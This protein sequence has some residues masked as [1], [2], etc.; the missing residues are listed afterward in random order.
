MRTISDNTPISMI[1]VSVYRPDLTLIGKAYTDDEGYYSVDIPRGESVTVRFDTHHTLNNAE[2]W[3]P[4]LVANVI[5]DSSEPLDR[6]L[7]PAGQFA[8]TTTG[9][10]VLGAF[11]LAAAVGE[12]ES[13]GKPDAENGYAHS[14]SARLSRIKQNALALQNIQAALLRYFEDRE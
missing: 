9:V 10:D 13:D 2:D 14:A 11:L 3:Q 1:K 4:S 12:A 5:A 7:A 8:D 6:H